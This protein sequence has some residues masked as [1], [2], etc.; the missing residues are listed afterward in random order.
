MRSYPRK[1]IFASRVKSISIRAFEGETAISFAHCSIIPT[2]LSTDD[3]VRLD[4]SFFD[5][6]QIK[7]GGEHSLVKKPDSLVELGITDEVVEKMLDEHDGQ[8]GSSKNSTDLEG[9]DAEDKIS[10]LKGLVR[11][12][13]SATSF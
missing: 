5:K 1:T 12:L 9:P 4:V 8:I 6:T 11:T 7:F 2:S 13:N 10:R 3:L